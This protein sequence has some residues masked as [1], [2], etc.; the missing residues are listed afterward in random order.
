M[1]SFVRKIQPKVTSYKRIT[2]GRDKN[3][4]KSS[5][6]DLQNYVNPL[7]EKKKTFEWL[8]DDGNKSKTKLVI[9]S[10]IWEAAIKL[11]AFQI[12]DTIF[13]EHIPCVRYF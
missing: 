10:A 8:T 1:S 7:K 3:R 6:D 9:Y 11:S 4:I 2:Q 5:T 13:Q 12:Q